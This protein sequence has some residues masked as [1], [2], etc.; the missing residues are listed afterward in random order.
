M[1]KILI[2]ISLLLSVTAKA[3]VAYDILIYQVDPPATSFN[4]IYFHPATPT[5]SNFLMYDGNTKKP[6]VGLIGTGLSWDGT[7]LSASG[8]S[9]VNADWAASSGVAQILNKPTTLAGYGITDSVTSGSLSSTLSG[10]ATIAALNTGLS[11]KFNNPTGTASQ[12]IRGDGSLATFSST[13][14]AAGGDLTGSY[15]NPTLTATGVSAGTYSGVAVDTKGRVS[16]G[17]SRGFSYPT[18]TLD[19][20]YQISSTRDVYVNYS[21]DISASLS[22]TN[23]QRGTVYLRTYTNSTYTTGT[24]EISRFSNGQTGT[25][26]VGLAL[27]QNVTGQISGQVPAGLWVKLATENNTGTPTFTY[28]SGQEVQL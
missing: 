25:L 27:V 26:T 3:Q 13:S 21:V 10:Y 24:Q 20:C 18:R 28:Q 12:Y 9:Q 14:G 4:G 1:K 6:M 15:P 22:L 8:G 19:A 17:T 11:A 7:T 16:A 23:G 5:T 2:L